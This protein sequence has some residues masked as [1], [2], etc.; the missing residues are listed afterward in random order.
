MEQEKQKDLCLIKNMAQELGLSPWEIFMHWVAQGE[1]QKVTLNIA[2]K[3]GD[4]IEA[5]VMELCPLSNFASLTKAGIVRQNP[6]QEVEHSSPLPE[7]KPEQ[8]PDTEAEAEPQPKSTPN[9]EPVQQ[10]TPVP[11]VKPKQQR[12]QVQKIIKDTAD[13]DTFTTCIK[14]GTIH[15]KTEQIANIKVGAYIYS[16]GDILPKYKVLGSVQIKGIVLSR[17]EENITII[18]YIGNDLTAI[19]SV[20]QIKDGWRFLT[21]KECRKMVRYQDALNTSLA[22]MRVKQ[23]KDPLMLLYKEDNNQLLVMDVTTQEVRATL[24]DK[25]VGVSR[26]FSVYLAKDLKIV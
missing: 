16:T 23:I 17:S 5:D 1:V 3:N 4:V 8:Q 20:A 14:R 12:L 2:Y 11:E 10:H 24:D 15:P 21:Y 18:K 6:P 25:T 7:V 26:T 13:T 19:D 22:E 9:T